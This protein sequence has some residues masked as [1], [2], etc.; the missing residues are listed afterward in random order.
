M[1]LLDGKL[2]RVCKLSAFSQHFLQE[3]FSIYVLRNGQHDY[4]I[5]VLADK[6]RREIWWMGLCV[7]SGNWREL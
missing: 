2:S 3:L 4:H 1:G 5:D 6:Q 7:S